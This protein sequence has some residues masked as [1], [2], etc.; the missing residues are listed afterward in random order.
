MGSVL[1]GTQ[2]WEHRSWVGSFYP[3]GVSRAEM[4]AFYSARLPTV[5]AGGTFYCLPAPAVVAD[6]RRWAREGFKFSL[7]VPQQV[8]HER[9]LQE[10]GELLQKFC[11]RVS[12]LGSGLGALLVQLSP[13]FEPDARNRSIL[14]EFLAALPSGFR[15]ALEFRHRAWLKPELLA[16][17]ERHGAALALAESRWLPREEVLNL[18]LR[19]TADFSYLRLGWWES[20]PAGEHA[21]YLWA[22]V[23]EALSKK[24]EVVYGYFRDGASG[25]GLAAVREMETVLGL[26]RREG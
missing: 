21:L 13:D 8:T 25:S 12:A 23:I 20:S 10:V 22:R 3:C 4:L 1:L 18:A 11:D 2:G 9:R 15:W 19:P 17:L 24:L 16:L 6:W 14:A 5:E 7:K 26:R